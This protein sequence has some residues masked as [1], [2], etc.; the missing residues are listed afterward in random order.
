MH[1]LDLF[2][3][4][5]VAILSL[6][7]AILL[8]F[9]PFGLRGY[10]LHILIVSFYYVVLVSSWNLL[11]GYTGQFSLAHHAFA[12]IGGYASGLL[13]FHYDTPI[14]L[15]MMAAPIVT[16]LLGLI[17]GILVL[18][19]R[20]IYLAIAT[21]AFGETFRITISA[22][23]VLTRGDAGLSVPSLFGLSD[24]R[25]YYYLFLGLMIVALI[26]MRW[27]V[28]SPVGSF[29]RAI[30]D[31]ELAA[32]AMGVNTTRWKLFVFS[33]TSCIAGTIG[34]FYAHYIALISPVTM[35]FTE[36][37]KIVIMATIGGLGSFIGPIVG[38]PLVQILFE[39]TREYG[40]WRMVVFALIVIVL[41]RV[42]RGGV[43]SLMQRLWKMVKNRMS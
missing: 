39:W 18:R 26:F 30:K 34:V 6:I 40:E 36:M 9:A 25:P 5:W 33:I 22:N 28:L 37:G 16:L 20:T 3:S 14:W 38:A 7:V 19:M 43:V 15:S 21:W 23:Y 35:R 42:E 10:Q 32:K 41:M 1:I 8:A 29:M 27:L 17:L 31:D 4:R 11:A 2:T 24:L 13:I 12:T